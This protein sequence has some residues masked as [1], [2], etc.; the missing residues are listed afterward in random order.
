MDHL[1]RQC[2]SNRSFELSKLFWMRLEDPLIAALFS[3]AYFKKSSKLAQDTVQRMQLKSYAIEYRSLSVTM[4]DELYNRNPDLTKRL[5]V[6][7]FDM[8]GDKSCI[9]IAL[10]SGNRDFISQP[11]CIDLQK[12]IW[13]LGYLWQI[14]DEKQKL[15][16]DK[17]SR[18]DSTNNN[19]EDTQQIVNH[20]RTVTNLNGRKED[21]EKTHEFVCTVSKI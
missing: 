13:N 11:A 7:K 21:Q 10:E 3:Y 17:L 15:D 8:Y 20:D 6:T 4:I 1:H 9:E 16:A 2:L 12:S 5:L 14:N 18:T 19:E